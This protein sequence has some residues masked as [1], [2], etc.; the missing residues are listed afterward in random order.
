[1][2]Q[3]VLEQRRALV[4]DVRDRAGLRMLVAKPLGAGF[5]E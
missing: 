4:F 3:G 1:V 5:F 2:L